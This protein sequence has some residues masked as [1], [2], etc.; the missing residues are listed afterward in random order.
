RTSASPGSDSS[1]GLSHS[2]RPWS[3][4]KLMPTCNVG[5]WPSARQA[6]RM[7]RRVFT[8]APA[9]AVLSAADRTQ[10]DPQRRDCRDDAAQDDRLNLADRGS[11]DGAC[12][13]PDGNRAPDDGPHGRVHPALHP[14][15][16]ERLPQDDL[17]NDVDCQ[18]EIVDETQ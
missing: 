8:R 5:E 2:I 7:S 6:S 13:G 12:K 15:E 16:R 14:L 18:H 11:E 1:V 3:I 9:W 17:V 10:K 4:S